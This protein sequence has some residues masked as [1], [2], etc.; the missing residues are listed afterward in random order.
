M[1]RLYYIT[2]DVDSAEH[3]ANDMHQKGISDWHFHVLSKDRVGLYRHHIHSANYLHEFDVVH[4]ALRGTIIGVIIGLTL[5]ITI[6]SASGYPALSLPLMLLIGALFGTWLGA[7][8]G[9]THENYKIARFH[10]DIEAGKYLI[11]VDVH[12]NEET[13]IKTTMKRYYPE[14]KMSGEDSILINPFKGHMGALRM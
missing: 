10:N 9:L 8:I 1:K 3:I 4:S 5:C 13:K 14:A 7:L 11:M 2:S 12:K 6:N